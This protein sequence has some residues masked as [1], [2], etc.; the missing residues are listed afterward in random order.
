M[1]HRRL[2]FRAE[3]KRRVVA[4]S[5]VGAAILLVA[6]A[7]AAGGLDTSFGSGGNVGGPLAIAVVRYNANGSRDMGFGPTHS[8]IVRTPVGSNAQAF[9]LAR[10]PDGKLVAAGSTFNGSNTDFALVRYTA[11]GA[12][13]PAFGTGGIVKT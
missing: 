4:L 9:A 6:A 2:Q 11:S 1:L 13:D 10:Q 7:A 5:T 8:G 3:R 12:L